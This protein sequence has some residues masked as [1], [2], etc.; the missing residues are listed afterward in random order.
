MFAS[1]GSCGPYMAFMRADC[2]CRF[3]CGRRYKRL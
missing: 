3:R 1:A 2:K